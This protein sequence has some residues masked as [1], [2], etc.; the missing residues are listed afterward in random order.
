ML[1]VCVCVIWLSYRRILSGTERARLS[2]GSLASE[3]RARLFVWIRR[4][5]SSAPRQYRPPVL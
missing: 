2:L 5:D 3:A 1:K 4:D